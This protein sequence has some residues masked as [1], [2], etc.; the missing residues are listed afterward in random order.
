MGIN[1]NG[2]MSKIEAYSKTSAGQQK[3]K[4]GIARASKN[5][6]VT[7]AGAKVRTDADM[8]AASQKMI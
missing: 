4:A 5:G 7:Q 3:I 2:I 8:R 1:V 6:G